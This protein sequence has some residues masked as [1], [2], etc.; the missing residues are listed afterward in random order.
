MSEAPISG[1]FGGLSLAQTCLPKSVFCQV[2]LGR[3][4]FGRAGEISPGS[5]R[6]L[7]HSEGRR[8]GMDGR[9]RARL[10]A[11]E[12][13]KVGQVHLELSQ[14]VRQLQV[15]GIGGPRT[16]FNAKLV[17]RGTNRSGKAVRLFS[18]DLIKVQ[19][20]KHYRLLQRVLVSRIRKMALRPSH[21]ETEC[22]SGDHPGRV[23]RNKDH[24]HQKPIR[25]MSVW[26]LGGRESSWV[27]N[28][29]RA[30]AD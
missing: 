11:V 16:Q 6:C 12:L 5:P 10:G 22:P 27:I 21:E 8:R 9:Y 20:V 4:R 25:T 19:A 23:V 28:R 15:A 18:L 30:T 2:R 7:P 29:L 26:A 14:H 17:R 1:V 3:K 24:G 13:V